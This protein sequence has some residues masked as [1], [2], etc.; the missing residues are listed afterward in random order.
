MTK[1]EGM[2]RGNR[3]VGQEEHMA[4]TNR[5]R[6]MCS[7][8]KQTKKHRT[9]TRQ[10]RLSG[11]DPDSTL[12]PTDASRHPHWAKESKRVPNGRKTLSSKA[13]LKHRMWDCGGRYSREIVCGRPG[14]C[15][16]SELIRHW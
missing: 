4:N 15:Q 8:T 10:T 2:A 14:R 7:D 13:A 3:E 11:Q 1:Q 16:L 5:D 6:A 12:P 9:G